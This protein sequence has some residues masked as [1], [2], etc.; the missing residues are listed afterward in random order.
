WP[1]RVPDPAGLDTGDAGRNL[2]RHRPALRGVE[3]E[4]RTAG[5]WPI[6]ARADE[7][8]RQHEP[9]RRRIVGVGGGIIGRRC[10]AALVPGDKALRVARQ[11]FGSQQCAAVVTHQERPVGPV[12][13]KLG[14]KPA[15]G[16]H[17]AGQR[18]RQRGIGAGSHRQTAIR[19]DG[20]ANAARVD[21]DQLGRRAV[22]YGHSRRQERDTGS[23]SS[24][25]L[26]IAR[27]SFGTA[28]SKRR[29]KKWAW[30]ITLSDVPTR[31]RGLRRSAA[32]T[33]SIAMSGWP[34]Q[35]LR[36]P[37]TS[38]PRAEFGLSAKVPR[39]VMHPAAVD[40]SEPEVLF[41]R[42]EFWT[43]VLLAVGAVV[44]IVGTGTAELIVLR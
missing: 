9:R 7:T 6:T 25:P 22:P 40:N 17:D 14:V 19:L 36:M 11:L 26:G 30:P 39:E 37:L 31:A 33:C 16:H 28:S 18:H 21:D 27:S 23:G 15:F 3:V 12:A 4:S 34:A 35:A 10:A 13:D 1:C 8:A 43:I 44:L 41:T 29:L 20:E 42:G 38:Q 5:D 2:R 24:D 32:S